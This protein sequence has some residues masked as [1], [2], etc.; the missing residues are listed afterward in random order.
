[1]GTEWQFPIFLTRP[2]NFPFHDLGKLVTITSEDGNLRD[3]TRRV[4]EPELNGVDTGRG[5]HDQPAMGRL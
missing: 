1:M 2:K 4:C 3:G 5:M